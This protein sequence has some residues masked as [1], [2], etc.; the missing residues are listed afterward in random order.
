[1]GG[2]TLLSA[3]LVSGYFASGAGGST[4]R[5]H[6][7]WL[8]MLALDA[9]MI[10][11][12]VA[13]ARSVP[14]G[15]VFAFWRAM[16]IAM[17]TFTIGD[18]GSAA[19]SLGYASWPG[20]IPAL[21]SVALS[22][23]YLTCLVTLLRHPLRWPSGRARLAFW[24]DTSTVSVAA[25]G[26]GWY[27]SVQPGAGWSTVGFGLTTAAVFSLTTFAG[28]RLAVTDNPPVARQAAWVL[29][30]SV[31]TMFM[32]SVTVPLP[33]LDTAGPYR[34]R[35]IACLVP[36]ALGVA[37]MVVQ[38]HIL[39]VH[40]TRPQPKRPRRRSY[41]LLPYVAVAVVFGLLLASLPGVAED[42]RT[43]SNVRTI[44]VLCAVMLCVAMV[45]TRQVLA[46]TDNDRLLAQLRGQ[47]QRISALLEHSSDITTILDAQLR[48]RYVSPAAYHVLGRQPAA[49]LSMAARDVLHPDDLTH[50]RETMRHALANPGSTTTVQARFQHADGSWRW[51]EVISTNLIDAPHVGGLISNSRDVTTA[52]E[53]QEMLQRQASHDPLT[54]LP[55]RAL[56]GD[57]LRA[58]LAGPA[59]QSEP[60]VTLLL[61]DL[62]DFKTINDTH[63]HHAGDRALVALAERLRACVRQSDLVAR[64]GGDEFAAI[65]PGATEV[66]A[67]MIAERLLDLLREPVPVDGHLLQ[68]SVSIG[69][70][71]SSGDDPDE[72][73]RAA[74]TAMYRAKQSGKSRYAA[75]A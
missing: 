8:A 10:G 7:F 11:F 9:M 40:G 50:V 67:R 18:I 63:G 44:G 74:D 26:F 15:P 42:A 70:A 57:R 49:L 34:L 22:T 21:Q 1:V 71:G 55:N 24:L 53:L 52:R 6:I 64:L 72:L 5:L 46:F 32:I 19:A 33:T 51:L 39:R 69:I 68:L 2:L 73:I 23:G 35:M 58:A 14:K 45:I 48:F 54:E 59:G 47:E 37:G 66:E 29:I 25:A 31:A 30:A 38:R 75:P 62:D 41:S 56:F 20:G 13:L 16:S 61:I 27:A 43:A 36:A 4:A 3:V 60:A 12:S 65:L 28:A 17:V